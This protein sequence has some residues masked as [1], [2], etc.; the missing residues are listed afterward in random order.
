MQLTLAKT[1]EICHATES[2]T[3]QM[4]VVGDTPDMM[5]H[6]IKSR[7][8]ESSYKPTMQNKRADWHKQERECCSCR[9]THDITNKEACPAYLKECK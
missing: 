2:M 3:A 5:V 4:K 6:A 7:R 8:S 9:Q 1:D